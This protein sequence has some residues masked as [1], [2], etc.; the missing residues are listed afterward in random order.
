VD[1]GVLTVD[2][3]G[4]PWDAVRAAAAL[5]WACSDAHRPCD[6]DVAAK[7]LTGTVGLR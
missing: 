5:A 4:D 2:P 7:A 1:G 6:T 3:V